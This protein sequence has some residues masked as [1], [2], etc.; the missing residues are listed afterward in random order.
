MIAL[1]D[2]GAGNLTS[3][4]KALAALGAAFWTP[5][6]PDELDG[7]RAMIVPGVGHFNATSALDAGWRAAILAG[8]DRRVP[9]LGICV[10]L[11]WLFDGSTEALDVPGLGVLPGACA[12]L[13]E[14]RAATGNR[15]TAI[16]HRPSATDG[17]PTVEYD[18]QRPTPNTQLPTPGSHLPT[19]LKI[20]HVGW[21]ALA[22]PK[23]SRLFEGIGS[24]TQVYFTHSYAAPLVAATVAITT[25]GVPF[26][27]AVEDGLVS[28]VQ[29]HPEKSGDVGL[30]ILGNWLTHVPTSTK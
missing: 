19:R 27:S 11:Q 30:R 26:S 29:F 24:G 6:S 7:A 4:R 12:L 5:A 1:V 18:A 14:S 9:L 16:D 20:P 21:N 13:S 25:H 8:L 15:Q 28:G 3:V 17:L 2:Y 22:F 10:G 23:P